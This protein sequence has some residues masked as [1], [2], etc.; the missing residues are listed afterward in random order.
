M[1][2]GRDRGVMASH[3]PA[4]SLKPDTPPVVPGCAGT[5]RAYHNVS[6]PALATRGTPPHA[7]LTL[8]AVYASPKGQFAKNLSIYNSSKGSDHNTRS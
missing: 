4:E 2:R 1:R 6:R 3:S 8:W 7:P 5:T